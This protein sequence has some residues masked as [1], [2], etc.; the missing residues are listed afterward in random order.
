MS[1]VN[2]FYV[3]LKNS[4]LFF[5][6]RIVIY[7]TIT[8]KVLQLIKVIVDRYYDITERIFFFLGRL[9]S[10][11]L[12]FIVICYFDASQSQFESHDGRQEDKGNYSNES[13]VEYCAIMIRIVDPR[14]S[15]RK[16]G[17]KMGE[18]MNEST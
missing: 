11:R 16:E 3:L 12:L 14:K 6:L 2:G 9:D 18:K 17:R 1:S 7:I 15:E 8:Y 10:E 5:F 4:F 13:S